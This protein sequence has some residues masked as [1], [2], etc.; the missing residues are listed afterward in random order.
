MI[1]KH[2]QKLVYLPLHVPLH[3]SPHLLILHL[4]TPVCPSVTTAGHWTS[5]LRCGETEHKTIRGISIYLPDWQLQ[6]NQLNVDNIYIRV[7]EDSPFWL[8]DIH[9]WT[10][11]QSHI[12]SYLELLLSEYLVF[13]LSSDSLLVRSIP[14]TPRFLQWDQRDDPYRLQKPKQPFYHHHRTKF[15]YVWLSTVIKYEMYKINIRMYRQI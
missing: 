14:S 3:T 10:I 15:C 4:A 13:S 11:V 2:K 9:V 8:W 12:S 6:I 1:R 5:A 7:S